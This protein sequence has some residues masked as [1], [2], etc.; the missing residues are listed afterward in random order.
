MDYDQWLSLL[1]LKNIAKCLLDDWFAHLR[2]LRATPLNGIVKVFKQARFL[3]W[4]VRFHSPR[5]GSLA[6]TESGGAGAATTFLSC[7]YKAPKARND[8]KDN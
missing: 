2:Y 6:H 1:I 3:C 4:S 5:W 7:F 8:Y